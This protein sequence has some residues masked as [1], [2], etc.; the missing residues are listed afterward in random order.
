MRRFATACLVALATL[1]VQ[2]QVPMPPAPAP[3]N[4]LAGLLAS[5][6]GVVVHYDSL[7]EAP[8]VASLDGLTIA[9][10]KADG[11][12]DEQNKVTI[13]RVEA[14][15]FD[16]EAVRNVF[17]AARYA[18]TPDQT[19]RTLA[20][21]LALSDVALTADGRVV[22]SVASWT[23]EG[24]AMKQ[25]WFVP[26]GPDYERQFFSEGEKAAKIIGNLLDSLRLAS[27]TMTSVH[28]EF[29]P[30]MMA[31]LAMPSLPTAP[32]PP[33][34]PTVY[35][36]REIRQ[37][38]VDRGRFGR[39][40]FSG[41]AA[42]SVL[43]T[44]GKMALSIADGSLE[45]ADFSKLLPF[46]MKAEWPPI[47]GEGLL[48]YGAACFRDYDIKVGG[49]GTVAFPEVCSDPI[50]FV[51]LI[52]LHARVDIKGMFTIDPEARDKLPAYALKYFP[53]PLDVELAVEATYDPDSGVASLDHYGFR[54][55]GFGGFDFRFKIGGLKLTELAALPQTYR[56]QPNLVSGEV[57]LIDEGGVDAILDMAIGAR[58][59]GAAETTSEQM[60]AQAKVGLDMMVG[61][62]GN[63]PEMIAMGKAIKDFIDGGGKLT[64]FALPPKPLT[65]SDLE[66]LPALRP[67]EIAALFGI[68]AERAAP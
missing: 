65:V 25:F 17:D 60:K 28:A 9:L 68:G 46:L 43:P 64:L 35:D 15:G 51:W 4:G 29:D 61:M 8:G 1:A 52:P 11:S 59:P 41:A 19:F 14:S 6:P 7:G 22:F 24:W 55:G 50:A 27:V 18:L 26:G 5:L 39:V 48:S 12:A 54:A 53:G 58:G 3:V 38:A 21:H 40:A 56:T 47:T 2:A 49:V 34:G 66:K 37:E 42:S 33:P 57:E 10:K 62:L 63:S 31:R 16:A 67:P 45:G 36:Y 20:S 32:M 44:G 30:T 13:R 23:F